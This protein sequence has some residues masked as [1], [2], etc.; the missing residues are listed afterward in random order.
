MKTNTNIFWLAVIAAVLT[1]VLLSLVP[2]KAL[3]VYDGDEL[4]DN[5]TIYQYCF[6][7]NAGRFAMGSTEICIRKISDL[8]VKGCTSETPE[9]RECSDFI[10][11]DKIVINE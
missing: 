3:D 1:L 11:I 9:N 5:P 10:V 2:A 6:T 8:Y 7:F 4:I